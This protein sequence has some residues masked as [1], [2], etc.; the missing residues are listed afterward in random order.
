MEPVRLRRVRPLVLALSL[1]VLAPSPALPTTSTGQPPVVKHEGGVGG[2]GGAQGEPA[3]VALP[4]LGATPCDHGH[5]DIYP[6][7]DVELKSFVPLAELSSVPGDRARGIW[8]WTDPQTGREYAIVPLAAGTAFVDIADAEHPQVLGYLPGESTSTSNREASVYA[9]HAFIVADGAGAEG[10]GIQVFNLTRLRSVASP[11]A[12]FSPDVVYREVRKVHTLFI[13]TETGFVYANGSDQCSGGLFIIDVR[14][15]RQPRRAGCYGGHGYVHDTQC[16]LY[17]GP[18]G[19]YAGRELCFAS[20][21]AH[22]NRLLVVDVTDKASPVVVSATPYQGSGYAHQG[23]LTEDHRHFL[24]DDE[25]DEALRGH[26]SRTWIWDLAELT[27]PRMLPPYEART[28]ST[29]HNQYVRDGFVYQ[30]NYRAGLRILDLAGIGEKGLA[31]VAFFDIVPDGDEPI[32]QAP[33]G[34]W[35]VYP[36]FPSGNVIVSGIEQGLYIL[37]WNRS[38][39]PGEPPERV[40]KVCRP[41]ADHLCLLKG[42]FWIDVVAQK[43]EGAATIKGRSLRRNDSTGSF[44]FGNKADVALVV[45]MLADGDQPLFVYAELTETPFTMRVIDTKSGIVRRYHNRSLCGGTESFFAADTTV[46]ARSPRGGG[47]CKPSPTS[48]CLS[49]RRFQLELDWRDPVDHASIPGGAASLSDVAG[50]FAFSEP[51]ALDFVAKVVDLGGDAVV[52]WGSLSEVE[53]TLR[54]TDTVTGTAKVYFNP[55]DATGCAVPSVP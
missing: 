51:K 45:K 32:S 4:A 6:C 54:V 43:G 39:A 3:I 5:A 42:R 13:N 50:G 37:R 34:A 21:A 35:N 48:L 36:F 16:V 23:W 28:Q 17:H 25:S 46:K 11:P 19:R 38:G 53:Y 8:G 29:D 22:P 18:D 30:A 7:R 55:L 49:R 20:N 24:L 52:L 27:A 41:G 47:S 44:H 14:Q 9:D 26:N 33:L 10:H 2:H 1:P 15:P 12:R 31:E 40:P